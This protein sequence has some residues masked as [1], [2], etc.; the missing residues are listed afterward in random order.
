MLCGRTCMLFLLAVSADA[1]AAD[2]LG[3]LTIG[4]TIST[5]SMLRLPD[6]TPYVEANIAGHDGHLYLG[7]CGTNIYSIDFAVMYTNFPGE[8]NGMPTHFTSDPSGSA[9][10]TVDSIR[11]SLEN[12]NWG[13]IGADSKKPKGSTGKASVFFV[14]KKAVFSDD[15]VDSYTRVVGAACSSLASADPQGTHG[16]HRCVFTLKTQSTEQCTAGL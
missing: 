14:Y 5:D 13:Y 1:F 4:Q 6:G 11:A 9:S 3:G 8:L 16:Y 10:S 7:M 2:S 12:L 15:S